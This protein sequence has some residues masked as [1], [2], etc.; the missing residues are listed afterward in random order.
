MEIEAASA[1]AR[2]ARVVTR[3][4]EPFHRQNLEGNGYIVDRISR[5]W[6]LNLIVQ[7]QR[8]IEACSQSRESMRQ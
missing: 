5:S 2:I 3:E 1:G 6:T 8:L 7:R 4:D